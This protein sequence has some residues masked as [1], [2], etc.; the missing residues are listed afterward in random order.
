MSQGTCRGIG[1]PNGQRG[2]IPDIYT[3][4]NG[5]CSD[6]LIQENRTTGEYVHNEVRQSHYLTLR[7][8]P[9]PLLRDLRYLCS[10]TKR[11]QVDVNSNFARAT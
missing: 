9:L 4:S 10:H 3:L 5:V 7:L 1:D 2:V 6:G 8:R 11:K